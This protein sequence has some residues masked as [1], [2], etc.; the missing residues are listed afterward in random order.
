MIGAPAGRGPA[1]PLAAVLTVVAAA[2]AV[3]AAC[4]PFAT[5]PTVL[6]TA[7]AHTTP[8][9]ATATHTVSGRPDL[10]WP[11]SVVQPTT[12]PPPAPAV[13]PTPT[14]SPPVGLVRPPR[15]QVVPVPPVDPGA[16]VASCAADLGNSPPR[17]GAATR[18]LSPAAE[19]QARRTVGRIYARFPGD[20]EA[21]LWWRGTATVVESDSRDLVLAVAHSLMDKD[22]QLAEEVSFIPDYR[23]GQKPYGEWSARS[24]A[25]LPGYQRGRNYEDFENDLAVVLL[26]TNEGRHI[27]DVVGAQKMCFHADLLPLS[28]DDRWTHLYGYPIDSEGG[29]V[30]DMHCQGPREHETDNN[31]L[32]IN[33]DLNYF[34]LTC[35]DG[36]PVLNY[37]ASGSPFLSNLDLETGIG[38]VVGVY[39]FGWEDDDK[40]FGDNIGRYL[41]DDVQ[42]LFRRYA[43]A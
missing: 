43:G 26:D 11:A 36:D 33:L 25:L 38:F 37:G 21:A 29:E 6:P 17:P 3:I 13:G 24:W 4:A 7:P 22:G 16:P 18:A 2:V 10:A 1:R 39:G 31:K 23:H 42:E 20:E 14:T 8:T 27:Q 34:F 30:L 5:R 28:V 9:R 19:A 35:V 15:Q 41:G 12:Q 40:T 32:G